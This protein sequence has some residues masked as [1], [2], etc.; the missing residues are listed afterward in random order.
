MRC[1]L[2]QEIELPGAEAPQ[3]LRPL[4]PRQ[5]HHDG[6]DGQHEDESQHQAHAAA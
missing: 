1:H 5:L 4:A 6:A 3:V 2:R